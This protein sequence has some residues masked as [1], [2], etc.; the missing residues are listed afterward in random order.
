MLEVYAFGN[1]C[2]STVDLYSFCYKINKRF[3]L[4][5][6]IG[7]AEHSLKDYPHSM[8]FCLL[9]CVKVSQ[10]LHQ[11]CLALEPSE[12]ELAFIQRCDGLVEKEHCSFICF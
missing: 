11:K 5:K 3:F 8:D 9:Q 6:K 7:S 2:D 10:K 4:G 1:L 12:Q